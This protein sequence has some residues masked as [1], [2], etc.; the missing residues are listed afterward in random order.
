MP[1]IVVVTTPCFLFILCTYP[2]PLKSDLSFN[3]TLFSLLPRKL[4]AR[5]FSTSPKLPLVLMV[6]LVAFGVVAVVEVA[7]ERGRE[8]VVACTSEPN[9]SSRAS[10]KGKRKEKR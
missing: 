2:N 4:C 10:V 8:E 9:I 6:L 1:L 7:E 5:G 3:L